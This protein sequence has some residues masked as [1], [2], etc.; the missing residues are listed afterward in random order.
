MLISIA[1]LAH[2]IVMFVVIDE[3]LCCSNMQLEALAV[4]A[5]AGLV[6]HYVIMDHSQEH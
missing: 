1:M 2:L 4:F 3:S 6:H 5:S